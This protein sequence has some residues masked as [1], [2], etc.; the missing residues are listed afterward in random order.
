MSELKNTSNTLRK[1]CLVPIERGGDHGPVGNAKAVMNARK[2]VTSSEAVDMTKFIGDFVLGL[3]DDDFT[4]YA[5]PSC[6][7]CI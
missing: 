4:W 5:C 7:R 3:V 1:A 2:L 6:Q